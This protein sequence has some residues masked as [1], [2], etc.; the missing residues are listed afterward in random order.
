MTTPIVDPCPG[1]G[2]KAGRVACQDLFNDVALRVRALAWTGS[3]QTWR[4]LHDVYD[5]QHEADFCGRYKG[6]VM[7]LGG[8]CLA[9][10]FG[11]AESGY[12]A[13]QKLIERNPWTAQTYPPA[14]GIPKD[15]GAITIGSLK[16]A[17]EPERLTN[18]VDRWARSVWAAYAPLQPLARE[19]V[20]QALRK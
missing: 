6:L 15:R 13:L 4:L 5:I 17:N 18:G 7:H 20:Q 3:M 19:W 11:G 12:R 8:V 2:Y 10:E 9:L 14:P 16:D 1:C